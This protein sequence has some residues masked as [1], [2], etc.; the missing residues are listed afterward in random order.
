[1]NVDPFRPILVTWK[2]AGTLA[3]AGV[4]LACREALKVLDERA[5]RTLA[6]AEGIAERL[7]AEQRSLHR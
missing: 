4:V 2:I 7:L 5:G 3:L 6:N 1:M